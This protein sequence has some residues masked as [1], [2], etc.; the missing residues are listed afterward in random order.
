M[1]IEISNK[2]FITYLIL[3]LLI[4][5]IIIMWMKMDYLRFEAQ[6][7]INTQSIMNIDNYLQQQMQQQKANAPV[8]ELAPKKPDKK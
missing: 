6:L 8:F 7:K 1:K 2:D 4:V 3:I 5:A